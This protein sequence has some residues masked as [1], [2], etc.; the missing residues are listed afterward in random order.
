MADIHKSRDAG[1]YAS[2]RLS[3]WRALLHSFRYALEG[4][5]WVWR[6]ERNFRVEAVIGVLALGLGS[7]LQ[8]NLVPL[9]LVSGLVLALELLNSAVESVVDLVS[10]GYHPLAKRAKDAGAGAVLVAA[11]AAVIVGLLVL[12]PPLWA[13]LFT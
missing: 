7:Y 4:L 2:E 12:G 10:P 3:P 5:F 13:R 8:V 11:V 9:V 1:T 6:N